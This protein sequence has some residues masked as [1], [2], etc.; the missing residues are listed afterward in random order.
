MSLKAV[1]LDDESAGIES[2]MYDLKKNCPDV[3]VI[4]TFTDT[5]SAFDFLRQNPI[6]VLFLDISMPGCNGFDFLSKFKSI[7]F[8]V[9]FVTAYEEY[10]LKA[11]DFYAVDYLLKPVEYP[12][13]I[14]A[15]E[16]IKEKSKPNGGVEFLEL[17][18][19]NLTSDLKKTDTLAIPT[20]D[21]F[22]IVE[23]TQVIYF[24]AEG[25]YTEIFLKD[26]KKVVSKSI[27]DFEK[28]LNI[29]KFFRIH[30]SYIINIDEV[31]KYV[32]GDGGTVILSNGLQL[33]VSRT[34]KPKLML[35]LNTQL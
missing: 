30:H 13:L 7:N 28:V 27:G 9:I 12:K 4:K 6:D 24:K 31:R 8:S 18:L 33:P 2:L 21:G 20:T 14:R 10:A 26:K 25:N 16:R 1:I 5:S 29:T 17:M 15:V 3:E 32:K 19:K 23:L 35:L 11:F 22:E 34:N